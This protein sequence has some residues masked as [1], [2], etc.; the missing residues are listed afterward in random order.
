MRPFKSTI[1]FVDALRLT[2]EAARPISRTDTVGVGDADGRVIAHDVRSAIDVPPFDRALMDGYAVC[3]A[4]TAAASPDAPRT[5][6]CRAR[7]LAGEAPSRP[8][9]PGECVEIATGAPLPTGADA[10]VMVEETTRD[11]AAVRVRTA[12]QAG[13]NIGPRGGDLQAGAGVVRGGDVLNPARLGALAAAGLTSLEAFARPTVALVSTGDELVEPGRPL[14]PGQIY[15]SNRVALAA[16][17][18]RHGGEPVSLA[19]SADDFETLRRALDEACRCDIVVFTG[20]SSVGER[21][22]VLDVVRA[23]GDVRYHG[24]AVKPGKP[25]A[26]ALVDDVPVFA[27]PGNPT[28]CLSNGYLLL[29]PFLR[30][31]ARLPSWDPDVV[32]LPLARAIRSSADRHQFFTVRIVDGA[33]EAAFK[34]SS[35]TTSMADA[36]GYIE[37]VP[38]TNEL[39]AGTR[40][41]V[42]L[43]R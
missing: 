14:G 15:E 43:F 8:L 4:D 20:G 25:T 35:A 41:R 40:V 12:V 22:L 6:L 1:P 9:A 33:V 37:I 16:L 32:E 7:V 38:G 5:L 19:S 24:I 18:R 17:V 31:V 28:S 10:V 21:D 2:L 34:G 27:M 36:D 26:F 3:A 23:R 29:V 42:T 13:Q 11:E 30:R 39:L